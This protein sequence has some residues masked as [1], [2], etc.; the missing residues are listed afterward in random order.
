MVSTCTPLRTGA[1]FSSV[2]GNLTVGLYKMNSVD[3]YVA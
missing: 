2:A 3:P 1:L